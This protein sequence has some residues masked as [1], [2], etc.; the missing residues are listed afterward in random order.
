[1]NIGNLSYF[2]ANVNKNLFKG[3]E[4]ALDASQLTAD[5]VNTQLGLELNNN[6]YI[7][8]NKEMFTA[9]S[10]QSNYTK[11]Q[12]G[13]NSNKVNTEKQPDTTMK[14]WTDDNSNGRVEDAEIKSTKNNVKKE[15][16][17]Y[18]G[19]KYWVDKNN[20]GKIDSNE[21]QTADRTIFVGEDSLISEED[22]AA[23]SKHTNKSGNVNTKNQ[24][25]IQGRVFID[26]NNN[27]VND[28]YEKMANKG[29]SSAHFVSADSF[30]NI[31]TGRSAYI[32]SQA[33]YMKFLVEEQKMLAKRRKANSTEIGQ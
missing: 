11:F 1:M 7:N 26:A 22:T 21:I 15:T 31:E 5:S 18:A 17:L 4:P 32:D 20:N 6:N 10:Y 29:I 2:K 23:L 8:W 28:I 27:G 33:D 24:Q 16:T 25:L 12:I 13:Q 30:V 19:M 3:Q 14:Y 9:A